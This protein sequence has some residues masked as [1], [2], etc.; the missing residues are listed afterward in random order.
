MIIKEALIKF[1]FA[2]IMVSDILYY[3]AYFFSLVI[4]LLY[5]FQI[6]CGVAAMKW[7]SFRTTENDSGQNSNICVEIAWNVGKPQTL[8][9]KIIALVSNK[10]Y[11]RVWQTSLS[12]YLKKIMMMRLKT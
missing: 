12:A 3:K 1:A 10:F 11:A 8:W 4:A 7:S 9:S 2:L 6:A 5:S